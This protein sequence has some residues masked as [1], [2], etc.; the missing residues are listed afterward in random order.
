LELVVEIIWQAK[1]L[2]FRMWQITAIFPYRNPLDE[3]KSY[4]FRL[5]KCEIPPPQKKNQ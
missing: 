2:F 3:W 4:F 5:E 1:L